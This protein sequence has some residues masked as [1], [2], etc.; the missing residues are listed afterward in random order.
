MPFAKTEL[1]ANMPRKINLT[2][3]TFHLTGHVNELF[4][5]FVDSSSIL[6]KLINLL[7]IIYGERIN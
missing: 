1:C 2:F 3:R 5:S 7:G 4:Y 6:L